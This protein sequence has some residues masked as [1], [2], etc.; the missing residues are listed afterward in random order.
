MLGR[1]IVN[2]SEICWSTDGFTNVVLYFCLMTAD[3]QVML[4]PS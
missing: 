4:G 2:V 3:Y 1:G